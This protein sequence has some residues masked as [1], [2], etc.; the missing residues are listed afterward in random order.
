MKMKKYASEGARVPDAPSPGIVLT[1]YGFPNELLKLAGRNI[2][3]RWRDRLC[4]ATLIYTIG[5][6]MRS[7]ILFT[8]SS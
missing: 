1:L 2:N 6:G 7:L 4:K 5:G 8:Q 3:H